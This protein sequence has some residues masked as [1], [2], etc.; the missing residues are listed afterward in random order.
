MERMAGENDGDGE[1]RQK[2]R[3]CLVAPGHG[4]AGG[5]GDDD[6]EGDR[7]AGA[8]G[9]SDIFPLKMENAST[10]CFSSG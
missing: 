7:D 4:F 8:R 1:R 6:D 2:H 10:R 3:D 9:S 5:R